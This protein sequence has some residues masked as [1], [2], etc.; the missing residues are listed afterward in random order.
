MTER[1]DKKLAANVQGI[2]QFRGHDHTILHELMGDS[3]IIKSGS[4][5]K[6]FSKI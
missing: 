6:Y 3:L 1:N 2:G 5:F 4:N